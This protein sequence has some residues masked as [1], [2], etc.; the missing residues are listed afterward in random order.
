MG[1]GVMI[2]VRYGHIISID[3]C[4]TTQEEPPPHQFKSLWHIAHP[5]LTLNFCFEFKYRKNHTIKGDTN[6]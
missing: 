6:R 1:K 2:F 4:M 5:R 3:G